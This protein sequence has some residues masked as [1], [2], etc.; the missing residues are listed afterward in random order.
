MNAK[1]STALRSFLRA[2]EWAEMNRQNG[3]DG[4]CTFVTEY[5]KRTTAALAWR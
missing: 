4:F 3:A 1:L 2:Q 5:A